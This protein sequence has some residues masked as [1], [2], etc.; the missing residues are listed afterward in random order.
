MA[1]L[2]SKLGSFALIG[3]KDLVVKDRTSKTVEAKLSHLVNI[4]ISDELSTDYLRGGYT[5]PKLLTI[6]GDRD[7]TLT[8]T[9]ATMST[10]LLKILTNSKTETKR[11]SEQMVED[12]TLS[13]GTF[14]ISAEI[15]SGIAPT[16]FALDQFGKE[17]KPALKVGNPVSNT[18]DYSILDKKITCHSSVTKVRVYYETMVTVETIEIADVT[19]KNFEFAGLAVAKEIESG[20]FY[21]VWI[22]IPNGSISPSYSLSAKNEASAPDSVELTIDCLQDTSKGYP[23]AISFLEETN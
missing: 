5:N 15:T 6:Y 10:D 1:D 3:I 11:K 4:N 20:K 14:N 7:I 21:K 16:I 12:L 8:A 13:S 19:P 23:I 18:T 9:S 22:E 2:T 17:M